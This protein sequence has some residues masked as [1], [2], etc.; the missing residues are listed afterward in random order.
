MSQETSFTIPEGV[1]I[2]GEMAFLGKAEDEL[3]RL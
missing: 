3:N 1:E 2:I